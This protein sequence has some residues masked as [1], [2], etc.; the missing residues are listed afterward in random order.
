MDEHPL[1]RWRQDK[2]LSLEALGE[3]IGV[4]RSA[5]SNYETGNRIPRP[6][7]MQRIQKVTR[8]K[9]SPRDFY[10]REAAE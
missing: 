8:G 2:N 4:T 1:R 9:V 3:Q 5:L 10:P 6:K 7:V